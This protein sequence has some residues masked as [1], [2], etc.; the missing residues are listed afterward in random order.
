MSQGRCFGRFRKIEQAAWQVEWYQGRP[1][2]KETMCSDPGEQCCQ[3]L[4]L[5]AD[6][7]G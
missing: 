2:G 3:S 4:S 6:M 1:G 5:A 7:D